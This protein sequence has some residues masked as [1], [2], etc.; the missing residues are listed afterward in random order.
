MVL[1]ILGAFVAARAWKGMIDPVRR[2]TFDNA[3]LLWHYAV[4]QALI[5]LVHVHG[6]PRL[7]AS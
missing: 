2:V 7:V 6:Y 1:A 4:V 3:R 5:G